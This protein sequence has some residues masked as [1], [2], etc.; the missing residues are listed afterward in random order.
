MTP[1]LTSRRLSVSVAVSSCIRLL[2]P[3]S[4]YPGKRFESAKR[5]VVKMKTQSE[6]ANPVSD[7]V[8][9]NRPCLKES[10][11]YQ[12]GGDTEKE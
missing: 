1:I 7:G 6:K 8:L 3:P 5:K 9:W 4:I 10:N 12:G 11:Y 2:A